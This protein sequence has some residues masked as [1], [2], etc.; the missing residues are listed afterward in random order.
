MRV[1]SAA[2]SE[3]DDLVELWVEL[4]AD[5]RA[6]GSHLRAEAN[7]TPIREALARHVAADGVLVA[8]EG[9]V[10]NGGT[11]VGSSAEDADADGLVGFVMFDIEAGAYEQDAT[12]GMV[13][14]LFVRPAYRDAGVGTRLLAAAENALA[15]AG[16]DAVALDV[17]ADNEAARRFYRR[18]GYRPHRVELEKSMR[19]DTHSKEDG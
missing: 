5:Q 4:A 7:R 2:F 9:D 13:R 18:H 15:D 1:S 8:R 19:S 11:E 10:S 12:R 17:L 14:N 6:S 16:V 3:L